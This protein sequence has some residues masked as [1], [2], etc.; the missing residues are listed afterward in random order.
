MVPTVVKVD[1]TQCSKGTVEVTGKTGG[2][3]ITV[4]GITKV[5]KVKEASMD[6]RII[7]PAEACKIATTDSISHTNKPNKRVSRKKSRAPMG[8]RKKPYLTTRRVPRTKW[9]K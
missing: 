7:T 9:K 8:T 4:E 6:T 1:T 5:T 2:E 3:T